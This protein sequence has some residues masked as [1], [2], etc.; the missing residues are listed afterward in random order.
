MT[1]GGLMA[2]CILGIVMF[3]LFVGGI[4]AV[5]CILNDASE[6]YYDE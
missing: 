2:I 4:I 3:V 1:D 5:A 6:D